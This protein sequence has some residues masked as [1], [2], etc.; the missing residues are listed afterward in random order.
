MDSLINDDV[1][2]D[3]DYVACL[4]SLIIDFKINYG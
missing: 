4:F 1:Y 3:L 2:G